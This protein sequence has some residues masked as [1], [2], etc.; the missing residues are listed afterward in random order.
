MLPFRMRIASRLEADSE[1]AVVVKSQRRVTV[2][3]PMKAVTMCDKLL[4]RR[5][6]GRGG[7]NRRRRWHI[8]NERRWHI[9]KELIQGS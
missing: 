4:Q 7:V 9:R 8:L 1:R 2:R 6:S 3:W 5:I